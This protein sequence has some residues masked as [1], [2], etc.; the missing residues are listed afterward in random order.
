MIHPPYQSFAHVVRFLDE[1]A[2]DP[3]V[4]EVWLTVYRVARDSAVTRPT[5]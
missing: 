5:T 1:A 3:D 4:E 2:A